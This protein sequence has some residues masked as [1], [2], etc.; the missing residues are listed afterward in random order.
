MRLPSRALLFAGFLPASASARRK[1]L[2]ALDGPWPVVIYE[3]PHRIVETLAD[4]RAVFGGEREVVITRELTKKFEEVARLPI[5]KAILWL[6]ARKERARGE[7]ALVLS[8]GAERAGTR[9]DAEKVLELLMEA[10]A[11]SEA[12]RLAAKITG[13]PKN[14]LYRKALKS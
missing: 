5:H 10:L 4:L 1:V 14:E 3:A 9:L 13:V 6:E 12:A 2:E 8:P 11:P 7:F